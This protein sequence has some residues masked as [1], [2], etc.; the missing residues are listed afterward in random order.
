MKRDE[1]PGGAGSTN[2][3]THALANHDL[4]THTS[5]SDGRHPISLLVQEARAYE[6]DAIA[7]TD[8]YWP[9]VGPGESD[10]AFDRYLAEIEAARAGQGDV[11]VL[12]GAEATVLD[13]TGRI[14]L[15]AVHAERLDWVLCDLGS[16]SE[17][18]FVHTPA[19]KRVYMENVI[20]TYLGLCDVPY[21]N[22]IAHPFN[23]GN[24]VPSLLPEEY[25]EHLLRELA[26]KMAERRI[27]FDVIN[28]TMFWFKDSGVAPRALTAQYVEVVRLF[29]REGVTFQMSSDDH[30]TGLGN[31]RW[32]EMVLR[33]AGVTREQMVDA[34]RIALK[35]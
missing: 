32:P 33:R 9:G 27:V 26:Q 8:H 21:L 10:E 34:R 14:S 17:G 19:D 18:T 13:V 2:P 30:R 22:A 15:D 11:R 24:T 5:W 20:R 35:G 3:W 6:L 23:T 28:S 12:R 4:H 1:Q 16:R 7:I 31:T 29:A 25:P